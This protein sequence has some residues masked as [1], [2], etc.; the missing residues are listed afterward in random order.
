[1]NTET[2]KGIQDLERILKEQ[3]AELARLLEKVNYL[4]KIVAHSDPQ[5][6]LQP[7]FHPASKAVPRRWYPPRSIR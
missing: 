3:R 7:R 2:C 6:V 1:M 5:S 4:E